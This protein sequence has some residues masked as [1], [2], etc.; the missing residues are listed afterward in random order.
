MFVAM[1]SM[2][3]QVQRIALTHV[4]VWLASTWACARVHYVHMY[5]NTITYIGSH[6]YIGTVQLRCSNAELVRYRAESGVKTGRDNLFIIDI[7]R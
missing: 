4:R 2:L 5:F 7:F 3:V 1:V 6:T